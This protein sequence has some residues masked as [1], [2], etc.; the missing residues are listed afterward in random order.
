MI[1]MELVIRCQDCHA[2]LVLMSYESRI[3]PDTLLSS[4]KV[5]WYR[6][7]EQLKYVAQLIQLGS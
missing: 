5:A 2:A 6:C 1:H 4:R 7:P 3:Q